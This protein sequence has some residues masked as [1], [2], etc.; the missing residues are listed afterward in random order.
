MLENNLRATELE[1][2]PKIVSRLEAVREEPSAYWT[3]RAA[4]SWN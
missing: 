1:L 4:P 2:D 3:T